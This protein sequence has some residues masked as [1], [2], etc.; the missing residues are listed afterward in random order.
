MNHKDKEPAEDS[1]SKAGGR[2]NQRIK[3]IAQANKYLKFGWN[4]IPCWP[5]TKNPSI[6][7]WKPYRNRF[8][9]E[10]EINDWFSNG[11]RNIAIL[12]GKI[13]NI[14]AFDTDTKKYPEAEESLKGKSMPD[15]LKNHTHNGVQHIFRYP[16][17]LEISNIVALGNVLGLDIRGDGGLIMVYPS[18]HPSGT[19]YKW[20]KPSEGDLIKE[21][22]EWLLDAITFYKMN[23]KEDHDKYDYKR[24]LSD[25]IPDGMRNNTL[26]SLA[27][28]LKT[29][30]FSVQEA[31]MMLQSVSQLRCKPPL[32]EKE[33][34]SIIKSVYS[35]ENGKEIKL[36]RLADI[37]EP[38][39]RKW[40]LEGLFPEK[41]PS[42][43]YA[44][45][46]IGKSFFALFMATQASRG[47]QSFLGKDFLEE[48]LNSLF[49]DW[50]L[51]LDDITC[52][53]YQ[54]A[55]GLGLSK[56]PDGLLYYTPKVNLYRFLKELPKIIE[57]ESIRFIVIDSLGA[58][59]VDPD[60]VINVIEVFTEL[61]NLGV[62]TQ[63]FD[64][65]PKL[66]SNES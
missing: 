28:K 36:V 49:L 57:S 34:E 40:F 45:G 19:Q 13:S 58:S 44:G 12:T 16:T 32:S 14:F 20:Q 55:R 24:A 17:D 54:V 41:Y 31:L 61:K 9:T 50:E 18:V 56:P 22:P 25:E 48:P 5:R 26:T 47:R 43:V 8:A 11:E 64:H 2:A 27:G 59:C 10:E 38:P 39:K 37:T 63:V 23:R 60:K 1:E 42:M 33:V 21:A 46:G 35:Y 51:E 6:K 4:V 15:T 52:R 29:S 65:Q 30:G 53:A 66:Q 7:E 62:T 3:I